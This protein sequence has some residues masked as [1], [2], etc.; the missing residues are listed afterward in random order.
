MNLTV[1]LIDGG[2]ETFENVTWF[3]VHDDRPEVCYETSD[4]DG[5]HYAEGEVLEAEE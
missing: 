3:E 5:L 1:G 4:G 2:V